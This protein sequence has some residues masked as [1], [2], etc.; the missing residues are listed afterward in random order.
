MAGGML[1]LAVLWFIPAHSKLLCLATLGS[2]TM[3]WAGLLYLTWR[4]L[5]MRALLLAMPLV[6]IVLLFLPG[7]VDAARLRQ[8]YVAS[9]ASYEGV[10]Y[11]WGGEG[12]R[13][14]DCS[15]LPRRAL[16]DALLKEGLCAFDGH[17]LREWL[18]QW[19]FD[20]S[21]Q[22][23]SE[24]YRGCTVPLHQSGTIKEIDGTPLAPGDLAITKDGMHMLAYR[25][26][27][28]WIQ[29]DPGTGFVISLHGK[30]DSNLWFSAPVTLHRWRVFDSITD[31]PVHH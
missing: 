5:W 9:M 16:R 19:W 23:L 27:G 4:R 1:G 31:K 20:A 26:D 24:G 11:H 17:A 18:V 28:V 12:R 2:I 7:H 30:N 21:A 10:P 25:G 6:A 13:G 15:G 22:A 8:T 29:A 3:A 14:I